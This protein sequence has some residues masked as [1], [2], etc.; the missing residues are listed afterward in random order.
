MNAAWV[1]IVGVAVGG[2]L[3]GA[4][5]IG[6]SWFQLRLAR[7]QQQAQEK[8]ADRQRRF[9]NARDLREYRGK[10]YADFLAEGHEIREALIGPHENLEEVLKPRLSA[11][12][13]LRVAVVV[14]GPT[15]M[16]EEAGAAVGVTAMI[17]IRAFGGL[18]TLDQQHVAM[19]N[20]N[21]ALENFAEAARAALE[22][23][24]ESP[25]S[26]AAATPRA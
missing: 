25:L 22:D 9:D 7:I 3:T 11:L 15:S 5:A 6:T 18:I 20:I 14:A 21:Q 1:G 10:A 2:V 26:T 12:Q 4:T 13:K 23:H 24:G 8:E 17:L 19:A 16:A